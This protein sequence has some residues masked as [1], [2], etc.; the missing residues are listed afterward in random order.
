MT[1]TLLSEVYSSISSLDSLG[2]KRIK[3]LLAVSGGSDSIALLH[4]VN[5]VRCKLNFSISVITINHNIREEAETKADAEFVKNICSSGLN[6]SIEC[7]VVEVPRGK[8]EAL[9]SLRKKGIEEAARFVRYRIFEK[10]KSFFK[11]DYILTAHTKDD[12]FEGVLM[13]IFGGASPS[14]LLGM[15][16]KRGYYVKPLLNIEKIRLKQYLCENGF[17]WKE[18]S[19]NNSLAYLR[20]RVR[21]CLI[22]SLN[23]TFSGWRSGLFKT[24]SRL[25]LDEAYINNAYNIFIKT[26]N[27]WKCKKDGAIF[28]KNT[29]FLSMPDCFKVRFLQ[30][31][32]V[33]LKVDYRVTFSSIIALIKPYKEGEST[34]YNGITLTI[35]NG[36]LL[37]QKK[38]TEKVEESKTGYMVWVEKETLI[39]IGKLELVVKERDKKYFVCSKKDCVGIGPFIPPFCI[40]SRLQG[41]VIKVNGKE[42]SV[43]TILTSWKLSLQEK[44][45]LPIIEV[46]GEIRALYAGVFGLKNLVISY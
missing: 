32:F 8:I 39:S 4:L 1:S 24:L 15:K 13:S 36:N 25:S 9:A 38:V 43:K 7:A 41:D 16:M 17:E 12:F 27:Y 6:E 2:K 31:G 21:H 20:N 5:E 34:S 18:D 40:R 29:E 46:D 42:K 44:N 22:P 33:L 26:I 10:A 23:L 28:C 14:S 37:L 45:I 19:T 3:L 30:E 35:K 11:A